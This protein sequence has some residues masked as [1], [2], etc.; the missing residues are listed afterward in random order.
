MKNARISI[1]TRKIKRRVKQLG[2][3]I[4]KDYAGKS[5][6]MICILKGSLYFFADITRAIDLPVQLDFARI[7]SYRDGTSSGDLQI[8]YDITMDIEGK[9]VIVVEDIVDSGRT[10]AK[11][12]ATLKA[13]NPASLKVC[14]FLDKKDAR[15]V[16]V[17]VDYSC[18]KI[19]GGFVVGYGLDLAE[20]YRQLPYLIEILDSSNFEI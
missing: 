14:S 16:E 11:F 7:S 9:D 13:K 17:N 3:Q 19:S 6:I 18:F 12:L 4:T 1:S 20:N 5:P 10:L 8:I 2:K 15:V